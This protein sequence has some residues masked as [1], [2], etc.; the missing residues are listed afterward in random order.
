MTAMKGSPGI[1]LIARLDFYEAMMDA[2]NFTRAAL[3]V[4]YKLLY[5]HMNGTTGRCDPARAT[6]VEET[7]LSEESVKRAI[8]ELEESGWW[9][10]GRNEGTAG[11]GGRT[12]TYRP[13]FERG[14]MRDPPSDPKEGSTLPPLRDARGVAQPP[15][16]GSHMTPKPG[17]NQEEDSLLRGEALLLFEKAWRL[18]PSRAPH[19]NPKKRAMIQFAA[20]F[21]RGADPAAIIRG[22]ENYARYI[23]EHVSD[24]Q[25]VAMMATWLNED[26]WNDHQEMA[27]ALPRRLGAGM[28]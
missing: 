12:N 11:P 3:H 25:R 26:R 27:Q 5:R 15:K 7:G 13:N 24:R 6:L 23:D 19:P 4:A 17:K 28:F 10:V 9:I 22:I 14:V 20:A 16:G 8:R 2:G 21:R 18:Y 1:A